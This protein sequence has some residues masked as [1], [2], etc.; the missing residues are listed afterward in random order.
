MKS[1]PLLQRLGISSRFSLLSVCLGILFSQAANAQAQR[2]AYTGTPPKQNTLIENSDFISFPGSNLFTF[3]P[4]GAVLYVP[5]A[6]RRAIKELPQGKFVMWNQ[7]YATNKNRICT[8]PV[9]PAQAL[10]DEN[11]SPERLDTAIRSARI[12]IATSQGCPISVQRD[13]HTALSSL[14]SK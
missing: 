1:S 11:I 6:Y 9:T 2:T 3:V 4:K 5:S 12:V 14:T 7:F 8:I 10:G 13:A